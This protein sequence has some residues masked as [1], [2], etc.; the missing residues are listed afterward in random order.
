MKRFFGLFIAILSLNALWADWDWAHSIGAGS[1]ERSWDVARDNSDN[2]F[3][4]GEYADSL[5]V[6][7]QTF[8]GYGLSD[9]F[10]LKYSSSGDLLW[11]R[12]WGAEAEDAALGVDTDAAGNAYVT[13]YFV[14]TLNFLGQTAVSA[15]V[16]DIYVAKL[17]P[18]GNL[19][20]LRTFG[21]V[22]S[23]IGQG[24][25]V[26]P[27]GRIYVAGWFAGT[28]KF[29][30]EHSLTAAGGSD[31]LILALNSAGDVLW[32]HSGASAGVDY[33]Y[34]VACD[35][36]G[37][38]YLTGSAAA[39][40]VFDTEVLDGNGMYAAKYDPQGQISWLA[41]SQGAL[42]F[43]ICV[44]PIAGAGR[45]GIVCGRIVGS[46]S[47]GSFPF[48]SVEETDD[49]YWVEFDTQTGAWTAFQTFGGTGTD[50]GRDC[51]YESYPAFVGS[52]EGQVSFGSQSFISNGLGDAVVGYGPLNG[53]SFAADGGINNETP[54][55][56]RILSDG[57]LAICGWHLGVTDF[58][59][60]VIDSGSDSDQNA[61]VAVYNPSGSF[62]NDP[63]VSPVSL[64]N[65]FPNPFSSTLR[66]S[67]EDKLPP[68]LRIYNERGQAVR[69]LP[70]GAS[71][72]SEWDGKDDTGRVCPT[73][74]YIIT[75]EGFSAAKALLLRD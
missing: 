35:D 7:G 29:S 12:A 69:L 31:A 34:K 38:A 57:R 37:N 43:S 16:W 41:S 30:A 63:V 23:E 61:F 1:M 27:E 46:G 25:A 65:A 58:G 67:S 72:T 39:G 75:G 4:A 6:Q 15:G 2:V 11:A 55:G 20:W 68:L 24:I 19:V 13:G 32:A 42:V 36:S 70:R 50:K 54:M 40:T 53:L 9:S 33:A 44:D 26:S 22:L 52:Y 56:I 60:V 47:I 64:L 62:I 73:G 18:S 48:S 49:I 8:P 3:V 66:I 45:K 28:V 59:N 21:G 51:D 14:G 17:D 71:S 74:I 10:L 5:N